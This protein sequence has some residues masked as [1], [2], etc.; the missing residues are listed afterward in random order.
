MNIENGGKNKEQ[1]DGSTLKV[2]SSE[3]II[4]LNGF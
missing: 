2:M 4:N 3:A 1:S